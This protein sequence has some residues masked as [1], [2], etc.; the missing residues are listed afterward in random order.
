MLSK[1][2]NPGCSAQ[3]LYLHSG[4]LFRVEQSPNVTAADLPGKANPGAK[5]PVRRLEYFWLCA[6][7]AR[8]MTLVQMKGAG[9]TTRKLLLAKGAAS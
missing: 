9:V 2:A 8:T 6:E 1:C 4:K 5:K 7:C 3:F